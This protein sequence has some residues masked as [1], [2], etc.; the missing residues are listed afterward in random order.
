M[1][2]NFPQ[3]PKNSKKLVILLKV[4]VIP[5]HHQFRIFLAF[6]FLL[7]PTF[8][9]VGVLFITDLFASTVSLPIEYIILSLMYEYIWRTHVEA[10]IILYVHVI[11]N[12]IHVVAPCK[13]IYTL[14]HCYLHS[15]ECDEQRVP[16]CANRCW[17]EQGGA[18]YYKPMPVNHLHHAYHG[19]ILHVRSNLMFRELIANTHKFSRYTLCSCYPKI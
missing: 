5:L 1:I 6:Q 14:P 7:T 19:K 13:Y 11:L 9:F 15:G 3:Q 2:Q 16:T 17:L 18:F 10:E 4:L 12:S 8:S